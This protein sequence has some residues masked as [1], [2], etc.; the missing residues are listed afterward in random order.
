MRIRERHLEILMPEVGT[1]TRNGMTK[2]FMGIYQGGVRYG[3]RIQTSNNFRISVNKILCIK[4]H[5]YGR[6]VSS[7]IRLILVADVLH[8]LSHKQL[9]WK[10]ELSTGRCTAVLLSNY[11]FVFNNYY[12]ILQSRSF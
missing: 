11:L 4:Q 6:D 5:N 12:W 7:R 3:G 8:I 9:G 2:Y 1:V 10:R